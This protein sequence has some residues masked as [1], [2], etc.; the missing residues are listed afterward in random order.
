MSENIPVTPDVLRWAR[1]SAGLSVDDVVKKLDRKGI[2]NI[3]VEEWESGKSS[4]TL[5][6]LERLAYE[7]YKRPLA[8]FFF[9]EPPEEISPK[10]SFRTLPEFEIDNLSPRLRMLLR[11]AESFQANLFELYDGVNIVERNIV[12]EL[13]FDPNDSAKIIAKRVREYIGVSISDQGKCKDS[14]EALKFWRGKLEELGVFIFKDA[15][16]EDSFSGFCL[17]DKQFPIVYINNSKPF[18]RQIFTLFHELAHLLFKTGGVDTNL[19]TYIDYLEGDSRLIEVLCNRFAGE[20][21]VPSDD[22]EKEIVGVAIDDTLIYGLADKYTVSREVILR[23]LLDRNLVSQATYS[24][25]VKKWAG[26]YSG[27]KGGGGNYFSNQGAYLGVKYIEKAFTRYY[28]KQITSERLAD[29]L[30]VKVKSLG[31]MEAL[32]YRKGIIT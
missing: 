10:Q 16:K 17:Y 30:G 11:K 22:F 8:L 26:E 32:L 23:K 9:P 24:E 29:Y 2:T 25:K 20:F 12:R 13:A 3:V 31:G 14:E 19:D 1:V 21:L 4:P 27:K 7:L 5:P 18:T 15:F 28:Q 6:Q